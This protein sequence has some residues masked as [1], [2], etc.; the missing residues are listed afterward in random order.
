MRFATSGV[1]E[2]G[3]VKHIYEL[4]RLRDH[5]RDEVLDSFISFKFR[6]FQNKK[7]DKFSIFHGDLRTH[8]NAP[9]PSCWLY[10][11]VESWQVWPHFPCYAANHYWTWRKHSLIYLICQQTRRSWIYWTIK[12]CNANATPLCITAEGFVPAGSGAAVFKRNSLDRAKNRLV[13]CLFWTKRTSPHEHLL[14]C[15]LYN[16]SCLHIVLENDINVLIKGLKKCSQM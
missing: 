10:F 14:F 2:N 15:L 13:N 3:A 12:R 11:L 7:D 4:I 1:I 9:F 16:T 8:F 6:R 5:G